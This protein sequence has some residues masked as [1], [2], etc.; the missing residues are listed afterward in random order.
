MHILDSFQI[1][2]DVAS[3]CCGWHEGKLEI[4]SRL[5]LWLTNP[6]QNSKIIFILY[7]FDV[8]IYCLFSFSS[9]NIHFVLSNNLEGTVVPQIPYSFILSF[10]FHENTIDYCTGK[11]IRLN[12]IMPKTLFSFPS[13]SFKMHKHL[14][15]RLWYH[16][17]QNC[18]LPP[19]HKKKKT[20]NKC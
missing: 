5:F 9:K 13:L 14:S 12:K 20:Q 18:N 15:T 11:N 1:M 7:I 10:I 17:I 4:Y 2:I 3:N 16:T 6:S 19:S 8:F